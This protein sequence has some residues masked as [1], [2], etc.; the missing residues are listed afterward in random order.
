M[1][2][3]YRPKK[4]GDIMARSINDINAVRMATGMGLVSLV[5][6]CNYRTRQCPRSIL[7]TKRINQ[8]K[9]MIKKY[10]ETQGEDGV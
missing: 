4:T 10:N 3:I 8:T 5:D 1:M 2:N 7:I 9:N 6:G